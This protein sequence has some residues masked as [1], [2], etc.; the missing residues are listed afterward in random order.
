MQK[1][2]FTS[3][4]L[5]KIIVAIIAGIVCSF[6][7]PE[8]LAR[9][10]I[11]FNG[12]FGNFLG[13][14]IPVLIFALITPAI[15]GIGRGAGKWLAITTGVAYASTVFAGLLAYAS[16]QAIY[17]WL[18]AGES[19][20]EAKD[21]DSGALSS[22]FT[23]EMPAPVGV[24]TALLLAFTLGVAMTAVKSDT[25]YNG[26]RDLERVIMRVITRFIIPLLPVYIFGMFLGMGMNGNLTATLTTFAKVLLLAVIMTIVLLVIQY[27]LVGGIARVNPWKAFATMLP[28]YGTALGTSS[29]A[30]TIPVTYACAKKNGVAPSVAGFTV[31]LCATTHLAGSMM[32]ICLFAFAI[33]SMDGMDLPAGKAIGFILMLG[34]TMV[35]APGVPG[36]AIMAAIGLLESMLGFS[37]EQQA[38]MIAAYIAIDSFGTACNVTGDG[39]IA[40][41]INKF[42]KGQIS[43]A[44]LVDT[45]NFEIDSVIEEDIEDTTAADSRVESSAPDGRHRL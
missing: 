39:A 45:P 10:F 7:L 26:V 20:A 34:V 23:I 37:P 5:F 33:M 44:E 40:L 21:V 17:P 43:R 25:L 16:S 35:A 30:A 27:L 4:L 13:F 36:G 18:L 42:A 41:I 2:K 29:S 28:A 15:A 12:L 19:T 24:M 6:F 8:P 3:T 32:K 9:V 31:P 11:T 14:F 22:Y 38:L 1:Q